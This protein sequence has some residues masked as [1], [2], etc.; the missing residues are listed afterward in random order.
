VSTTI[1]FSYRDSHQRRNALGSSSGSAER[2]ALF[3]L[4]Q[5]AAR[6]LVVRHNLERRAPPRW[7]ASAGRALKWAVERAGGYG[8][9]FATVLA[10]LRRANSAD[11]VFSTVD[12]VGI[13]LML[14]RRA[15]RLRPPLVYVAIGLPERLVKLR[16]ERMRRLYASALGSCASVVAYSKHEADELR[17]WLA[18]YGFSPPVA[19]VP[20]G[21]DPAAFSPQPGSATVDVVSVGNDP[22]RDFELL[23]RVASRVPAVSFRIV[24]SRDHRRGLTSPPENVVVETDLPFEEMRRRLIEARVVAL[25]VRENSYSGATTVLLQAMALG[26][27]VVVT[28]T[29]AIA[30]G[31]GLVD[32]ENCRLVA[33]GDDEGFERALT[34]VLRDEFHARALGASARATI[35]RK[36]T[37][38][39]YVDRI[40]DLL[41]DAVAT[42]APSESEPS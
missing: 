2:Y 18:R 13:P 16:S 15:G 34:G 7:A 8:G 42:R 6:G 3:G 4:D 11:V 26:K 20:F 38:E 36:L 27:P 25:P 33:P 17:G 10:S 19:F 41:L 35:E 30:T 23:L 29:N 37:W 1:F 40:E 5:L 21:V 9:D 32:G 24:A 14:L 22:H 28:R 39:R 31:Y 12:T